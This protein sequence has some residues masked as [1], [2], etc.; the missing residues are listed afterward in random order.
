MRGRNGPASGVRR[1]AARIGP[2]HSTP[3]REIR[4]MRGP[5]MREVVQ[6][7]C[8]DARPVP[9]KNGGGV[10]RQI[11]IWP[12]ES[13]YERG[14]FEWRISKARVHEA[15]AFSPFPGFDRILV[16]LGADGLFL[17]HGKRGPRTLVRPL[18]PYRFSGDVAT[19]AELAGAAVED[20]NVFT[21]VGRWKADVQIV[22]LGRRRAREV[23][24]AGHVFV[25]ALDGSICA[26]VTNE[27]SS[28]ELRP[29]NTLWL[30]ESNG[31]EEIELAG[32][33]DASTVI[34]V[35]IAAL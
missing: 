12:P 13:T 15:G 10:T 27:E 6:L 33:V 26:R 2:N 8:A 4:T 35:R 17:K 16:V 34:L 19:L 32:A 25:H 22:A 9:W 29:G 21:R 11:A 28:F 7:E 1:A 30:R 5:S 24:E 23:F 20:F 3:E 31:G 14:D 18:E